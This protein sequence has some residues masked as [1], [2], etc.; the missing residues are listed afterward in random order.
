ML[1]SLVLVVGA[2]MLLNADPTVPAT[3]PNPT[4]VSVPDAP[5]VIG[6]GKPTPQQPPDTTQPLPAQGTLNP[7]QPATANPNGHAVPGPFP[8]GQQLMTV[9]EMRAHGYLGI[10]RSPSPP[11]AQN[12]VEAQNPADATDSSGADDSSA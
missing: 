7:P 9:E 1:R 8:A 12:P 4:V 10:P 3:G 5:Q 2:A 11:G 6:N